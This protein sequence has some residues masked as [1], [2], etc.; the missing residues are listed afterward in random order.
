MNL[1]R[2]EMGVTIMGFAVHFGQCYFYCLV[3]T[4]LK[5]FFKSREIVTKN[6]SF[7][8][9]KLKPGQKLHE[10]LDCGMKVIGSCMYYGLL[11]F[12]DP[13]RTVSILVG[14]LLPDTH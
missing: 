10:I 11:E 12:I 9:L 8:K 4:F 13:M 14:K 6:Q 3:V 2:C 1:A 5:S 7:A